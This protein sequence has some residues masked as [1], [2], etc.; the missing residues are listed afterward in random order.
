MGTKKLNHDSKNHKIR[1][2]QHE[3]FYSPILEDYKFVTIYG[4]R[5]LLYTF[6]NSIATSIISQPFALYHKRKTK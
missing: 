1:I 4:R 6:S 5:K 3:G 2:E